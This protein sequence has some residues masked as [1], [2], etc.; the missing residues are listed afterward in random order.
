MKTRKSVESLE[1]NLAETIAQSVDKMNLLF[2]SPRKIRFYNLDIY[3]SLYN[4]V[5]LI[6]LA[7][8]CLVFEKITKNGNFPMLSIQV[9]KPRQSWSPMPCIRY[10]N[11]NSQAL[12]HIYI[13]LISKLV[14]TLC[15]YV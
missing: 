7:Q 14:E 4:R 6:Y 15:T 10:Q 1:Q 12:E 13:K 5:L 3:D 8:I 11:G 2:T 9:L